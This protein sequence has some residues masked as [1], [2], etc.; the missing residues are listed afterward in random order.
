M[1]D[2][3][4]ILLPLVHYPLFKTKDKSEQEGERVY[5]EGIS[6]SLALHSST[7]IYGRLEEDIFP[8]ASVK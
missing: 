1:D 2:P 6:L 3:K 8:L 7:T 4:P 5:F